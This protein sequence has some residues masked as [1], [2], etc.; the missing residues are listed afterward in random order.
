MLLLWLTGC[1]ALPMVYHPRTIGPVEA[2]RVNDGLLLKLS[3]AETA[4][5]LGT[6]VLFQVRARNVSTHAFWVPL[7]PQQG[8]YWTFA[9]GHHDFFVFDREVARFYAPQDCV[10]LQPGQELQFPGVVATYYFDQ[11]GVTEFMAELA[12]A[13][14]TNPQL[15]PFWSGR[16]FSNP[17]G[18]QI[19][20]PDRAGGRT[21]AP[22]YAHQPPQHA[23]APPL[24]Y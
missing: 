2:A 19:S 22:A 7:R 8:F 14:N 21:A 16:A 5:P 17:F 3:A 23:A 9:N 4:V 11:T 15:T 18:V 24:A 12:I 10:L 13:R 1:A 6:P 20:A